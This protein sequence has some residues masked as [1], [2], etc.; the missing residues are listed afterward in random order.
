[1]VQDQEKKLSLCTILTLWITGFKLQSSCK[2]VLRGCMT[3]VS[4]FRFYMG[5][6]W[7]SCFLFFVFEF[8]L[9]LPR[10]CLNVF[11]FGP[12]KNLSPKLAR[13][14]QSI[15]KCFSNYSSHIGTGDRPSNTRRSVMYGQLWVLITVSSFLH[16]SFSFHGRVSDFIYLNLSSFSFHFVLHFSCM[17]LSIYEN[18]SW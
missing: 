9:F 13:L 5:P 1:M 10:I 2:Y 11:G 14:W 16:L 18:R 4:F 7:K 12:S 3:L 17:A 15:K 6:S 8:T